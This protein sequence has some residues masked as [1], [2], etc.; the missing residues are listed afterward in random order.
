MLSNIYFYL[1]S[2]YSKE[3]LQVQTMLPENVTDKINGAVQ[4][5]ENKENTNDCCIDEKKVCYNN[6]KQKQSKIK[7]NKKNKRTTKKH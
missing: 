7:K 2:F 5:K 1:T 4:N 3:P 6:F